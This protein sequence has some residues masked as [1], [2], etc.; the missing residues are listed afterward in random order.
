VLTNGT[1]GVHA[2]FIMDGLKE[3]SHMGA[4]ELGY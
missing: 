2:K 4:K 1:N 3:E